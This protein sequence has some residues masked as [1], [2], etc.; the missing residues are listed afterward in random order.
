VSE[1]AD[2]SR[3]TFL[4]RGRAVIGVRRSTLVLRILAGDNLL[5]LR[6]HLGHVSHGEREISL[7]AVA[8]ELAGA[9]LDAPGF[10]IPHLDASL[11][12]P[13]PGDGLVRG[14]QE[15]K[16]KA[17]RVVRRSPPASRR[18]ARTC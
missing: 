10:E 4:H 3:M 1:D 8:V 2:G 6:L 12:R 11:V 5:E 9:Q 15:R 13:E 17:L 7:D 14:A 16:V 18:G